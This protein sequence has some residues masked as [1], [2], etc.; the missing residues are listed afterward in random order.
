MI[1]GRRPAEQDEARW[2]VLLLVVLVLTLVFARAARAGTPESGPAAVG[3]AAG[4]A[5]PWAGVLI[6]E[7][8][9]AE[10]VGL[11]AE[12]TE[13]RLKVDVRDRE[14]TRLLSAPLPAAP[15]AAIRI[16]FWPGLAVGVVIGVGVLYLASLLLAA[17]P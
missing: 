14:L 9:V 12:L 17:G 8:R 1:V 15:P 4:E 16:G 7:S 3:L 2:L 13:C 10:Y 5:A 11:G 6:P